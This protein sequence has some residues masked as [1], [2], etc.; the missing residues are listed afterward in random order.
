MF[1]AVVMMAGMAIASSAQ[2]TTTTTTTSHT[3]WYYPDVNVYY[4]PSSSNYW[5]WDEPTS[6]WVTVTT[7]PDNISVTKHK[8]KT[9]KYTG[10][11][12]WQDE[13]IVK[14]Y[15]VKKNGKVKTKSK[16]PS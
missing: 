16:N 7:L 5:Y 6:K 2:T 4:E 11:D 8:Y 3:Y 10:T 9:F 13:D 15:K 12:P 14:K 1:L